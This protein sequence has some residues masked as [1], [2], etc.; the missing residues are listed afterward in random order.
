[1]QVSNLAEQAAK[2]IGADPVLVRAGALYHDAGKAI[3]PQY[4]IENQ[5]GNQANPHN[6]LTPPQSARIIIQHV[7][8]GIALAKKHRLPPRVRDFI[9]EHH[10]TTITRY[11][12]NRAKELAVVTGETYNMED[13]RYPGPRPQSRETALLMLADCTEAKARADLPKDETEL[14]EIVRSAVDFQLQQGQLNDTNLTFLDLNR[15]ID[16]FVLTLRNT[17]HPRLRYPEAEKP[18]EPLAL[19][20]PADMEETE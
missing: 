11:Q 15:T 8:D 5:V 17:Y 7:T 6:D 1:L 19:E 12:Y 9:L 10:G 20:A 3:N 16:S 13:Y 14:R 4:F 18:A 2:A